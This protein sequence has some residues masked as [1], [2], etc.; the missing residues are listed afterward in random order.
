MTRPNG[1]VAKEASAGNGPEPTRKIVSYVPRVDIYETDDEL[2]LLCDLPGVK[3]GDLEARFDKG[4]LIIEGKVAGRDAPR[5][6][7]INEYGVGD[8]YRSFALDDAIDPNKLSAEYGH[9]V[10]TVHLPK[11]EAIR[12]RKIAIKAQ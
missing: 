2:V 12:P 8:F 3:P 10:L 6:F 5:G 4:E 1:S 9:G 7:A 11:K